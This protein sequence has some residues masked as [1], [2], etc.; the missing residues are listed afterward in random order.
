MDR[1]VGGW[2]L[3]RW[4]ISYN[5][6][7]KPTFPYGQDAGGLIL[8]T[9]DGWMT[10]SIWRAGRKPLSSESVRSAPE[11]ERLAAFESYFSYGGRYEIIGD[12]VVHTVS[13]SLNPNFISTRQ[14][15]RMTFG[16]DRTLTL[17]ATDLLPGTK[18]ERLHEL[19]WQRT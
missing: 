9:P 13:A 3:L 8:Y 1:L 12:D 2:Q 17:S 19:T 11:A 16:P 7:R 5:D 4:R 10:A 6:G 14:V 18:V 15:R